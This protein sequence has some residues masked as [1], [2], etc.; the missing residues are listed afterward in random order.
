ME[1]RF[2]NCIL[3]GASYTPLK[4]YEKDYLVK[5][6]SCHL[7]FASRKPTY[8]ELVDCYL[9][10]PRSNEISPITLKRCD[11]LLDRFEQFRKTNKII[12]VGAG[13]GWFL[14]QAKKRGWD[15]YG[16]EFEDRAIS[17][18]NEKGVSMQKGVL[19]PTNYEANE[20]DVVT[21]FEVVEHINNPKEEFINFNQL[22][23]QGG[24][25]Y[26]TTPNFNSVSRTLLKGKWHVLH[27]PE[28]ITYYVPDTLIF[29]FKK[30]GFRTMESVT[31]GFSYSGYKSDKLGYVV[32]NPVSSD[33]EKIRNMTE[34]NS[35]GRLIK[36]TIN[37]CLDLLGIGDSIKAMF[38]KK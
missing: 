31:S 35:L 22:L 37:G 1:N 30:A 20:F 6:D 32:E 7:V 23:R 34:N 5:C 28:H 10:Y 36:V 16:T 17:L 4:G 15:V 26:V 19:D 18:C 9:E 12:D 21:S 8:Q 13:E 27:Y 38:I 2:D 14:Y 25:V 11:Q 24:L 3:C 33:D 29:A